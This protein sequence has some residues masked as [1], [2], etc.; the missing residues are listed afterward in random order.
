MPRA[1]GVR[2]YTLL[3]V[4]H[5]CAMRACILR[6]GHVQENV[7]LR[8]GILRACKDE[9]AMFC[10]G[11]VPGGARMFRCAL[12]YRGGCACRAAFVFHACITSML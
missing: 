1:G 8:P 6:G 7:E 10:K 5:L 9:R 11:V 2:P 4:C 3:G 12:H